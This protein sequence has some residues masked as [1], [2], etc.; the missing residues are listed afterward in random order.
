MKTIGLALGGGAVLGAA[1]IGVLK[2]LHEKKIKIS[3][4]SG[5]SIGALVGALFAYGKDWEEIQ[6]IALEMSWMD[7]T[8]ISLSRYGLLSN[9]KLGELLTKYI[10]N[11][12]IEDAGIPLAIVTTDIHTGQKVVFRKGSVSRAVIAST[13]I[14]GIFEPININ[15]QWLMD[16]GIVENIPVRTCFD[17]GAQYVI[18]VDLNGKQTGKNPQNIIDIIVN[19]FLFMM[20]Q[21]DISQS[22]QANLTIRPDLS[23]YNWTHTD[24]VPEMIRQGYKETL[25]ALSESNLI[26]DDDL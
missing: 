18:G 11:R 21:S 24:H 20:Q 12:Q 16:G 26:N 17:I 1:H 7:I 25:S 3:H 6:S 2:A 10:G 8:G 4:I 15:G 19:S 5:T 13:C 22:K 23:A 9:K 14:P